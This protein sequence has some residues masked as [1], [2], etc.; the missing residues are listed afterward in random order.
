MKV[1]VYLAR[2]R[3][4]KEVELDFNSTVRDLV[5]KLGFTVQGVVVLRNGQPVLDDEKL[6]E[7]D[8]LTLVQTA[9][10]G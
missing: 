1:T 9:S 4:E 10:G 2:E 5:R 6:K 8:N 7:G 3:K